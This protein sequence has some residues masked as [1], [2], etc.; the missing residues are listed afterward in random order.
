MRWHGTLACH[1]PI[2]GIAFIVVGAD[3][4]WAK[5]TPAAP[6][7]PVSVSFHAYA[8]D[9]ENRATFAVRVGGAQLPGTAVACGADVVAACA[10]GE[11]RLA[12][13]R[14]EPLARVNGVDVFGLLIPG[15]LLT[16]GRHRLWRVRNE[17]ASSL[18]P[19]VAEILTRRRAGSIRVA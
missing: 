19:P 3:V 2:A 6:A 10:L 12:T 11:S 16:V 8:Q 4:F 15:R 7:L 1:A 13:G 17:V 9:S 5:S 14:L 18:P